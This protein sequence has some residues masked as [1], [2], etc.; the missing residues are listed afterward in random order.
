MGARVTELVEAN[1]VVVGV[2]GRRHGV[3]TFEV[4]AD[5]VVGAD[6]RHSTARRLGGFVTEYEH[7]AGRTLLGSGSSASVAR[8]DRPA[9][10]GPLETVPRPAAT[11]VLRRAAPPLDPAFSFRAPPPA[12]G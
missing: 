5:G 1:G 11:V 8:A 9:G 12:P 6:G 7:Q 10:R 3:E 2:R 4:R